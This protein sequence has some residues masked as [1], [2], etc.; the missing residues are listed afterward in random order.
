MI[1]AL[2][3]LDKDENFINELIKKN[4]INNSLENFISEIIPNQQDDI[5]NLESKFSSYFNS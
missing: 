1:F 2:F 3:L 5:L 4:S